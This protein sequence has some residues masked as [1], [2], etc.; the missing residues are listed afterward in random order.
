MGVLKGMTSD[1]VKCY[2]LS[3]I[4]GSCNPSDNMSQI[5]SFPQGSGVQLINNWN[6]HPPPSIPRGVTSNRVTIAG[7]DF[8]LPSLKLTATSHLKTWHPK[9]K[10]VF[11]PSICGCY[12]SFR[13]G[14]RIKIYLKIIPFVLTTLPATNL[15]FLERFSA[16]FRASNVGFAAASPKHS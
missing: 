12:V 2:K 15:H 4:V 13:E 10:V 6:H 3:T 9:R 1:N 8:H 5:G 16:F 7:Y 11:Q 14:N